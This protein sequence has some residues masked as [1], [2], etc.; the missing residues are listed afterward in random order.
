[1]GWLKRVLGRRDPPWLKQVPGGVEVTAT[2]FEGRF[3]IDVVGESHYQDA[4]EQ[5][6]GGRTEEGANLES[7]ALL[8]PEPANRYDPNAVQ[9]LVDGKLVGYLSRNNAEVLQPA[10]LQQMRQ[11][12][13]GVACRSRVVGGWDRGGGDRGHFGVRLYFDPADFGIDPDDLEGEWEE[14]E[15]HTGRARGGGAGP[16][17]VE[18]R[19]YT[20]YVD[21][22]RRLRREGKEDEAERLLLRLVDAVEAE[23]AAQGWG[24]APWY[25]ERLAIIYRKRKDLDAEVSI[26]ERFAAQRHAPGASAPR[27]LERLEKTRA[28]RDRR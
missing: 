6:A 24:V 7:I 8:V 2:L 10:I 13:R 17:M 20:E 12:G 28:L 5:I 4:L 25:Y 21:E 23:A 19:H 27:L 3:R 18:G 16:G 26:L 22:V 11:T 15:V 1:M 9:I 14:P